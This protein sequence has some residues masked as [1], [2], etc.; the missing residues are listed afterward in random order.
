MKQK[1]NIHGRIQENNKILVEIYFTSSK[2]F[3]TLVSFSIAVLDFNQRNVF[4][5]LSTVCQDSIIGTRRVISLTQEINHKFSIKLE[6]HCYK[7]QRDTKTNTV[8]QGPKLSSNTQG[9]PNSSSIPSDPKPIR[10]P[11]L[12]T[13]TGIEPILGGWD[14]KC[15]LQSY[16][17]N[18]LLNHTFM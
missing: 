3:C 10:V 1:K 7:I 6:F 4:Q 14:L 5:P 15:H 9:R 17:C 18:M 16:C 8:S 12:T 13:T 11:N 2:S